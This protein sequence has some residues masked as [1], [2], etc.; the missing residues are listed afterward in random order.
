MTVF[1]PVPPVCWAGVRGF[2]P[3]PDQH[4]G[5]LNNWDLNE[6]RRK[7][8]LCNDICKRLEFLV[9]SRKDEKPYVPS[10]ST[11]TYLSLISFLWDGKEP[12]PRCCGHL[13][14]AGWVTFKLNP[15]WTSTTVFQLEHNGGS[16]EHEH[17]TVNQERT[18]GQVP[19]IL[20]TTNKPTVRSLQGNFRP[21][22]WCI[23]RGIARLILQGWGL[24]FPC[25]NQT[26][27][28]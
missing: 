1:S 20:H 27:E 21:R 25:N 10:H 9:F 17:I 4:S 5:S 28:I 26:D 13:S 22:P 23:D 19:L 24:R 6:M 15:E 3:W 12:R 16:L 18:M 2:K 11:F 8:C 14:W 7:C